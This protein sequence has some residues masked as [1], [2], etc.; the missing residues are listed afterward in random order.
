MDRRNHA[1]GLGSGTQLMEQGMTNS[2]AT[3][4]NHTPS[5]TGARP[6]SLVSA[7][8]STTTT[9]VAAESS[10]SSLIPQHALENGNPQ[11]LGIQVLPRQ[12]AVTEQ[13]RL[14]RTPSFQHSFETDERP[15]RTPVSG[16]FK[17]GW[18]GLTDS[19]RSLN[20]RYRLLVERWQGRK[21]FRI[22]RPYH[23]QWNSWKTRWLWLSLILFITMSLVIVI[24]CLDSASRQ[25]TG[26]APLGSAPAFLSKRPVLEK[27]LWSQGILYTTLPA[28]LMTLYIMMVS[29]SV[30]S[31][32]ELQPFLDLA[33]SNGGPAKTTVMLDYRTYP[34]LY[35]FVV[36]FRNKHTM[37]GVYMLLSVLLT[38]AVVPLTA[39][40]F[41]DGSF[42][43]E[44]VVPV[45]I[46]TAFDETS[47]LAIPD[48]R[49]I[50]DFAS[51]FRIYNGHAPPWTDGEY[52]FPK[53]VAAKLPPLGSG[54]LT[55][56]VTAHSAYIDCRIIP[57]KEYTVTRVDHI[58][59]SIPPFT[60]QISS[61]DCGCVVTNNFNIR[62]KSL[63]NL[64]PNATYM[65]TW[66]TS[67]TLETEYSRLSIMTVLYNQAVDIL[68]NFSIIS[69]VP[70]YWQTPGSLTMATPSLSSGSAPTIHSF[71]KNE[72]DAKAF[73]PP[74]VSLFFESSLH[75]IGS[76]NPT[77]DVEA[78]DFGRHILSLAGKYNESSPIAPE[79]LSS[80]VQVL[81]SSVYSVLLSTTVMQPVS[82]PVEE[83]TIHTR[84]RNRLVVVSPVAYIISII[85]SGV[86]LA[87][88][89]MFWYGRQPSVLR[90]EPV[91]ILSHAGILVGSDLL[92]KMKI[93]KDEPGYN[94][95][96]VE[97]LKDEYPYLEGWNCK[98]EDS[99]DHR[100]ARIVSIATTRPPAETA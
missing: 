68:T 34:I 26:F 95:K 47:V 30:T 17:T 50:M 85:L 33:R 63:P 74:V 7:I 56:N 44:S 98:L 38:V 16:V 84:Q 46:A 15:T 3:G 42:N 91:G 53:I 69:C 58:G 77:S 93:M 66:R 97:A 20:Q 12:N 81:F 82:A 8:S 4:S 27:A 72:S 18:Q 65:T 73:R 90:E 32:V 75:T 78:N 41:T 99:A 1:A 71:V 36:A 61:D 43:F 45:T 37:L 57:E 19:I 79:T 55:A 9:Q 60:L 13:A 35:S 23:G 24:L 62:H 87:I 51:A 11:P 59:G 5:T 14:D 64:Q 22:P 25:N 6:P 29:S 86:A 92:E 94:G 48:L 88:V 76:F 52:A 21:S 2:R 89:T 10:T 40:L 49:L 67:C 83:N 39:F 28:F 70:S 80:A 54:N 96:M 100:M 31:F